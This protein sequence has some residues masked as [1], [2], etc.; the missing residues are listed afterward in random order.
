MTNIQFEVN[1]ET[2]QLAVE[3]HWTLLDIL[4]NEL[5]LTGTKSGCEIGDCCACT[6]IFEGRACNSCLVLAGEL[7][8]KTVLTIEGISDDGKLH[9]VQSAF[10]NHGAS[11]CGFC[12]PGMIMASI[13]LLNRDPNPSEDE[14]RLRLAGNICRCTGYTKIVEAVLVARN[15]MLTQGRAVK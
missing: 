11:Q 4:R 13:A 7:D 12:T 15:A 14:I 5:N 3:P 1:G 8:G 6:V 10:V 2:V 9:P